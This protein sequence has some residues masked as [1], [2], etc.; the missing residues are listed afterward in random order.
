MTG[1]ATP[2]SLTRLCSV[3]MFCLIAVSW[4][5][6]PAS[7]FITPG[8]L[9][10]AAVLRR[11]PLQVGQ[12]VGQQALGRRQRLAVAEAHLDVGAVAGD[13]G[14]AQV[15]VAQQRA[16]VARQ[17]LGLLREGRLHVDLHQEVHAA[18]QVQAQVHGQRMQRGEPARR[19]RQQVQRDDVRGSFGSGFSALL[20]ASLA[21]PCASTS[22]KRALTELRRTGPGWP[23][24]RPGRGSAATRAAMLLSSL[25]VPWRCSPA[26][27]RFAEE[28]RQRVDQ[29][30]EQ[31]DHQDR[32]F[33]EG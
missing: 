14:M 31:R 19:L 2:S 4:T 28:V 17:R 6:L 11:R 24:C 13:A 33:P 12:L 18:A 16:D 5:R 10:V 27:Q 7:G 23:G 15:P 22:A 32:V 29:A 30:D 20:S 26:P 25:S 8:E 21:L 9:E 3:V 1:S